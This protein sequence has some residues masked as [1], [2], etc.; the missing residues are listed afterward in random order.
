MLHNFD[1]DG[2]NFSTYL[3]KYIGIFLFSFFLANIEADAQDNVLVQ[4][5]DT[6]N[7]TVS[8]MVS[9]YSVKKKHAISFAGLLTTKH[10][11]FRGAPG[12]E[13][14]KY[15]LCGTNEDEYL[16]KY[17]DYFENLLKE[18]GRY[19]SFIISST[20]GYDK[21]Q[22]CSIIF[23]TINAK[24]LKDDLRTFGIKRFGFN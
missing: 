13:L 12:T 6:E 11:L 9:V 18:N 24:A 17:P 21:A 3:L 16:N 1:Q 7:G 14:Y 8:F 23:V 20:G 2:K 4:G 19:L 5:E 22:K 15:P 10:L